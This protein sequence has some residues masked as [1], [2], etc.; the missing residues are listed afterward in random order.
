MK[1]NGRKSAQDFP[2]VTAKGIIAYEEDARCKVTEW[3]STFAAEVDDHEVSIG[4]SMRMMLST[5]S[6]PLKMNLELEML[7]LHSTL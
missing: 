1:V 2:E 6:I 3:M 7:L 4:Y 5:R